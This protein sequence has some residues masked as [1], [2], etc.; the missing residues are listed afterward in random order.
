M[1]VRWRG[2]AGLTWLRWVS[3][4]SSP[5]D[6]WSDSPERLR[7]SAWTESEGEPR[8]ATGFEALMELDLPAWKGVHD[9]TSQD[10]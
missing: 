5:R 3:I 6:N 2:K 1:E 10:D 8:A 7:W 9:E 4:L